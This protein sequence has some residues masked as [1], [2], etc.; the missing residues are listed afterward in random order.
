MGAIIGNLFDIGTDDEGLTELEQVGIDPEKLGYMA[1]KERRKIL[2]AL[3]LD[4]E[5]YDF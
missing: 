4:P 2:I 1:R 5:A 3:G